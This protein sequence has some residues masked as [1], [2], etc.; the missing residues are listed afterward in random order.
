MPYLALVIAENG[1]NLPITSAS[2]ILDG[3]CLWLSV[4][5][6]WH[7]WLP[8][9]CHC[10]IDPH[11]KISDPFSPA[12][13]LV[14]PL[15]RAHTRLDRQ[16][17][18]IL[19]PL[20]QQTDQIINRQHDI[21]NQ[22]ILRHAHIPH[23]HPH[24]QHLLELKL[25]RALHLRHLLREVLGMRDRG[26]EL[27]G[28]G[29][30]GAQETRDLAHERVGGE[31]GVVFARELLDELFVLVEFLQVVG[32]HGVHAVVFG[33]IDVVLVA[34]DAVCFRT[35]ISLG[36]ETSHGMQIGGGRA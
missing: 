15:R 19:P 11:L 31:E 4:A 13:S 36:F 26:G 3:D 35:S 27:A 16:A 32:R 18:H 33:P 1:S 25:D 21:A 6:S 17:P 34:E 14:H 20:L 10:T 2:A 22:L 5:S 8:L 12:P 9:D 29:E 23:R 30:A 24:T 7:R 28:L